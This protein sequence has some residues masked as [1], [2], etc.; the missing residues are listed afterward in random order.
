MTRPVLSRPSQSLR[1]G[2]ALAVV[3]AALTVGVGGA[4]AQQSGEVIGQ[5]EVSFG[6]QTGDVTAGTSTELTVTVTNRGRI[7]KGGPEQ[8]ENRVTTARAMT[9]EFEDGGVPIDVDAGQIAVGNVPTGS[10]QTTVPITIEED[11]EAGR[12]EVPLD[13]EYQ[14]T[15]IADYD[16]F[17]VEYSDRTRTREDS[18]TVV[19]TE[20]ARF[21]VVDTDA[22]AQIGDQS[23]VSLTLRNT[24]EDLARDASVGAESRSEALTFD[25]GGTASTAFVGRWPAGETRT[26]NYSVALADD[27]T[28]RGYTLDLE[29]DYADT[30][31]I[32]RTSEP[33]TTGVRTIEEQSFAIGEVGSTLRVGEDG[34]LTGTVTNT[35]PQPADSVVVQYADDSPTVTPREE[36]VAVGTLGPGESADFRLPLEVSADAEAGAK[37]LDFAVRYRNQDDDQRSYTKLDVLA[38]VAPERDQFDVE[39][40]DATIETGGSLTLSVE[41]TNNLNETATDVEGRLFAD[42]P[43]DTGDADTG[44]IES[45]GPGETTTMTFELTASGSATAG[46]TYPISFDFR[47]DDERGNSQLS[48]TI[49]VPIDTVEPEDGGFPITGLLIAVVVIVGV[50]AGLWYRRQ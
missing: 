47:Y 37:S 6:T 15:R 5:P 18:I 39:L 7:D 42:D 48:D 36:S 38:E 3:A 43:L 50:G 33:I 19:V 46:K 24:G 26:V 4:L 44:Y 16:Q 45:I 2:I 13:Y 34:D 11:A 35:G 28:L 9:M 1:V 32:S 23:D 17:G 20:D 27:A 29:V 14:S 49:R 21:A 12:Y 41:V 10:V 22:T 40:G 30:D 8:Y 25:S 31:G